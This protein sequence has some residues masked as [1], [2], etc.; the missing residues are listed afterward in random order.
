MM[1][2]IIYVTIGLIVGL[3][4]AKQFDDVMLDDYSREELNAN[5]HKAWEAKNYDEYYRYGLSVGYKFYYNM[6]YLAIVLWPIV[7]IVL[8]VSY[9][10]VNIKWR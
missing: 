9:L 2:V 10:Y 6:R 3:I 7:L 4:V 5:L 8:L 1:Y